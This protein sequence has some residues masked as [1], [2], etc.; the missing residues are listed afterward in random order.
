M[1]KITK[2][3]E[4][5]ND[6]SRVS[7]YIN[8]KFCCGL[9]KTELESLNLEVSNEISCTEILKRYSTLRSLRVL[10][11]YEDSERN[12]V[13]IAGWIA[14]FWKRRFYFFENNNKYL[15]RNDVLCSHILGDS[16]TKL[17]GVPKNFWNIARKYHTDKIDVHFE[18]VDEYGI[19][20]AVH[21]LNYIGI[22]IPIET[23]VQ[24]QE[25]EKKDY[26]RFFRKAYFL[27]RDLLSKYTCKDIIEVFE[28][29]KYTLVYFSTVQLGG[30]NVNL[31]DINIDQIWSLI[32]FKFYFNRIE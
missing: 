21:F 17:T 14:N 12:A 10:E 15:S 3:T 32:R 29:N 7:I 31:S 4:Q 20:S 5:V 24:V 13:V 18:C 19:Q 25:R 8:D 16:D 6:P 30:Q 28:S 27:L 11:Q 1:S 9:T 2:I 26:D 22:T 23:A